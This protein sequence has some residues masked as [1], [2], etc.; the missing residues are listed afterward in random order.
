MTPTAPKEISVVEAKLRRMEELSQQVSADAERLRGFWSEL[1]RRLGA[2]GV[3]AWSDD[4][5]EGSSHLIFD[6]ENSGEQEEATSSGARGLQLGFA[7]SGADKE[8][9]FLVCPA[10]LV[11]GS[12]LY[13]SLEKPEPSGDPRPLREEPEPLRLAALHALP[14]LMDALLGSLND[15]LAVVRAA[16]GEP[17]ETRALVSSPF[18]KRGEVPG[19]SVV[20]IGKD[21]PRRKAGT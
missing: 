14:E 13:A 15:T 19:A 9:D 21:A 2:I 12:T 18:S 4:L 3:E 5:L 16:L 8:W 6:D 17:L 1:A 20:P 11:H 7:R 10:T